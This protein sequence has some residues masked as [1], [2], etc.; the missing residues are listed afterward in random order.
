PP[1]PRAGPAPPAPPTAGRRRSGP[2]SRG[3]PASSAARGD[4]RPGAV[5]PHRRARPPRT[6]TVRG[7]ARRRGP[8]PAP[9]GRRRSRRDRSA[10]AR[11]RRARAGRSAPPGGR[12]TARAP[13]GPTGRTRCRG[14]GRAAA[15]EPSRGPRRGGG[16]G[17]SRSLQSLVGEGAGRTGALRGVGRAGQVDAQQLRLDGEEFGEVDVLFTGLS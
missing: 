14:K 15:G 12:R 2:R 7:R 8:G 1:A 9:P 10:P 13:P 3:R 11:N 17:R 5:P 16:G 4:A 6:R